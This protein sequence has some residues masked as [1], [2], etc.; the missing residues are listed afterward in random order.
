MSRQRT[1]LLRNLYELRKT[2]PLSPRNASGRVVVVEG[3]LGLCDSSGCLFPVS[4][5]RCEI[6]PNAGDVVQFSSRFV[7]PNGGAVSKY[8]DTGYLLEVLHVSDRVESVGYWP[9]HCIPNPMP[10]IE[11]L[12]PLAGLNDTTYIKTETTVRWNKLKSRNLGLARIRG[13]FE[14]RGFL[15][16]ETPT[17]VPS[18][19]VENYLNFFKTSY[20]DHR[21]KCWNLQLPTS[22][23]FALKK[24]LTEGPDK[25]FQIAKAFRNN[26]E[27][28]PWHEPEFLMLEWYRSQ[29]I[30]NQICQDTKA[31]VHSLAD[32][33][34]SRVALPEIWPTFRVEDLFKTC[35]DLNLQQLQNEADFRK[36]ASEHSISIVESDDWD[37]IFCKLFME[38]IEP[39]LKEQKACFVTH[40]PIQMGA[41]AKK[42]KGLPFVE[43][44]EAYLMGIE[45]C[46]GYQELTDSADLENRFS[47][48]SARKS[49]VV[50]DEIFE[51]Y[52][53]FGLPT[54]AGNAF[55][56]DRVIA[57]LLGETSISESLPISFLS[58]FCDKTVAHE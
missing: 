44:F 52:M 30:L 57:I 24:L 4:F 1:L 3:K 42:E 46:N 36:A 26:G 7:K 37:S 18:G 20:Q 38:K 9:A 45:I 54:C 16:M 32:L 33:L 39:Y 49:N 48:I 47:L 50:R 28:G 12:L 8:E 13:F 22:P 21:G 2:T 25:I 55:G 15:F 10:K 31:L 41:L 58:Q 40:F 11:L 17:I 5:S 53:K 43:R 14:N 34:Q 35:V 19:G 6:A 51:K 56:V 27:I 29:G 23:E